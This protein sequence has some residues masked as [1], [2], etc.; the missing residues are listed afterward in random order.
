MKFGF[1]EEAEVLNGR[2]GMASIVIMVV[3][4]ALTGQLVPGIF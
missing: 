1:T 3:V 4:Y 2:L